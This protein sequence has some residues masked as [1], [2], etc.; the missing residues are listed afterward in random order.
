MNRGT[1]VERAFVCVLADGAVCVDWG[2]G[3]FQDVVTGEF[4]PTADDPLAHTATDAELEA[5]VRQGLAS[6]Y[7]AQ[8]AYLLPLPEQPR[9]MLD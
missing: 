1:A 3:R 2:D 7:D 6:G 8:H 5:L 4:R 9:D